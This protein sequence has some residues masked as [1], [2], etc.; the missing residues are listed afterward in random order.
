MQMLRMFW[1]AAI[2]L[3][4]EDDTKDE[5]HMPLC[6]GGELAELWRRQGL[7]DVV[8]DALAIEMP[9][10]SFDDYWTPF[11]EKQGPAGTYIGRA[12]GRPT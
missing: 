9:F 10:G 6:G 4:P 11:T 8:E 2:A 3:R 5:R 12:R 1:D 7:R